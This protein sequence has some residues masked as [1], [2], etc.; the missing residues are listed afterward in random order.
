[1]RSLFAL[2]RAG[3]CCGAALLIAAMPVGV[4]VAEGL[5][6]YALD[7]G[8]VESLAGARDLAEVSSAP[9]PVVTSVPVTRPRQAG[10]TSYARPTMP[11]PI[12]PVSTGE[13]FT[14]SKSV[15][16]L[17]VGDLEPTVVRVSR[18]MAGRSV[19]ARPSLPW[20]KT[21]ASR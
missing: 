13:V 15:V 11:A 16:P 6:V 18:P 20:L 12:I 3:H 2:R 14:N 8:V 9:R 21:S 7:A 4:T 5:S 17:L 10:E 1:M 19:G